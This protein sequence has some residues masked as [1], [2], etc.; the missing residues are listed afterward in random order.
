MRKQL[1]GLTILGTGKR[2]VVKLGVK[3]TAPVGMVFDGNRAF[4][5]A[6][7]WARQQ[8]VRRRKE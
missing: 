7:E 2:A 6:C 1:H 8:P 4:R 3:N 5:R